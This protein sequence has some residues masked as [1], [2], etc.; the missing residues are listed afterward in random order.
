MCNIDV[1]EC[2]SNPCKNRGACTNT[3]GGFMCS[4]RAGYHGLICETDVDD[5]SPS[6]L[7]MNWGEGVGGVCTSKFLN[8][9]ETLVNK[10]LYFI[11]EYIFTK[12]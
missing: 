1:N 9:R 11:F 3:M 7:K 4:C 6:E 12:K 2:I 8:S 5:C 10:I